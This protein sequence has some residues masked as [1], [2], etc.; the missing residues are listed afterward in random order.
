MSVEHTNAP[1]LGS[2]LGLIRFLL[3]LL[4]LIA[5]WYSYGRIRLNGF[6]LGVNSIHDPTFDSLQLALAMSAL[7]IPATYFGYRVALALMDRF[8]LSA[9][10]RALTYGDRRWAL[11]ALGL[12]GA[13]V[14]LLVRRFILKNSPMTDDE[15]SYK[16]AAELL[17]RGYPWAHSAKMPVFFDN[18]FL[19][20]NGKIFSAY[21]LGWPALLSLGLHLGLPNLVNP[22]LSGITTVLIALIAERRFGPI[23]GRVAALLFVVSPFITVSA[24]TNMSHTSALFALTLL[25]FACD[26]N[27]AH[28]PNARLTVVI[29]LGACLA[30]WIRP[31][32]GMGFG[33]PIV[34]AWLWSLR[35]SGLVRGLGQIA[36]FLAVAIG[37]ALL[38]FWVNN[39][40][41]GSPFKTGYHA[42]AKHGLETYFR[43]SPFGP[44]QINDKKFFFF[45]VV[46]DPF[47]ILAKYAVVLGRLWTDSWG[48]PLGFA[49]A[50][51][52]SRRGA[53]LL[54]SSSLGL[55]IAHV[56]LPD[57]GIDTFGPVHFTELMLPLTLA[58]TDG[59]RRLFRLGSK[60]GRPGLSP[61]VLMASVCCG[62][63][64]YG[65]PRLLTIAKL[66]DDIRSPML[67]FKSAPPH[68]IIFSRHPFAPP[69]K[70]RPGSHFVF[71]R[72]NNDPEMN[73]ERLW[74]NHISLEH[75][76]QLLAT[77]PGWRGYL[78]RH[79]LA[80]CSTSLVP[81]EEASPVEFPPA[82]FLLPGDLGEAPRPR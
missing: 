46:E 66:A 3:P 34:L 70:G 25:M 12:L 23:W 38:F 62:G 10:K 30:F 67:A 55:M 78:L 41:T 75:D 20:N 6:T 42:S 14:P 33:A 73:N 54:V 68:S 13:L 22:L 16:F 31:A 18:A 80:A 64:F 37:P 52:A 63:V 58:S 8:G 69:C 57:A 72:P 45:F 77:K 29:A 28:G 81:I 1:K 39:E 44:H 76:R 59:L 21:F 24:A 9:L 5:V 40:L 53:H 48:F 82:T 4:G 11:A 19:I 15:A 43:F 2:P 7:G 26:R 32:T 74:A 49:L 27:I 65:V 36:I 50:L 51:L 60:L 71:F 79:D 47:I 61:A 56:P 17:T 35:K